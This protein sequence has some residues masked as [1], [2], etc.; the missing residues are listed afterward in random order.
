MNTNNPANKEEQ[1]L[2]AYQL[3]ALSKVQIDA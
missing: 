1:L 2:P 3:F